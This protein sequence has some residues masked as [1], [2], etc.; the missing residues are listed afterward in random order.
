MTVD[1]QEHECQWPEVV[2]GRDVAGDVLRPGMRVLIP[3]SCGV[4]PLDALAS[5]EYE[6]TALQAALDRLLVN[7]GRPLFHWSPATRRKQ[8][9]RYGLRPSMRPTTHLGDGFIAAYTCF[10]DTPSWAWALSG[11][12]ASSPAGEWDLWQTWPQHLTDPH[13]VPTDESNGVHEVR[14]AHRVY[15]RHLWLTASRVKP[16]TATRKGTR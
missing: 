13:V 11:G 2:V 4:E 5:S 3:C 1:L 7:R 10:G 12:Q 16:D 6:A 9:I 14:T 15:K 8:I